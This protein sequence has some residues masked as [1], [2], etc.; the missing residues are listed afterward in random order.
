M[1]SLNTTRTETKLDRVTIG[2]N[3]QAARL[4]NNVPP[5]YPDIARHERLQGT[6][7][8]HAIIGKDRSLA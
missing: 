2:G 3:V 4:V 6:V 8:L 1:P 7:K 5:Q